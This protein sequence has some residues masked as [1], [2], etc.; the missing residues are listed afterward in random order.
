M[1]SNQE[2]RRRVSRLLAVEDAN[3]GIHVLG[4]SDD[5]SRTWVGLLLS[6]H[7]VRIVYEGRAF[8]SDSEPGSLVGG[9]R[10]SAVT[11]RIRQ[12]SKL[13]DDRK[14]TPDQVLSEMGAARERAYA[15]F[16]GVHARWK[17]FLCTDLG[18]FHHDQR[19]VGATIPIMF[20]MGFNP[21]EAGASEKVLRMSTEWGAALGALAR[22]AGEA[23][24]VEPP[25]A[26]QP[27]TCTHQD[28]KALFRD[29]RRSTS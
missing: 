25:K 2:L 18:V 28:Y 27:F 4:A 16:I 19:L 14:R 22:A 9:E 20:R 12:T 1:G 24:L 7:L 5:P 21:M 17:H 6:H 23:P 8:L 29:R 13:L 15:D 3:W 26:N 10:Y 11:A